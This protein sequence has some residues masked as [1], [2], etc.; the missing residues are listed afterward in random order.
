VAK[1][2]AK[3]K[4]TTRAK[5]KKK[6]SSRASSSAARVTTTKKT[7]GKKKVAASKKPTRKKKTVTR[8][9]VAAKKK[10][11]SKKKSPLKKKV[12]T[13]KKTSGKKTTTKK[14]PAA[15][16]KPAADKKPAA[17][18]AVRTTPKQTKK[19]TRKKTPRGK[20]TGARSVAEAA[21]AAQA[22][23]QGYVYINGRRVRMISTKGQV[24]TRRDRTTKQTPILEIETPQP[25]KP[26]KTKLSAKDLR[27]FRNLLLIKRAELVGDLSAIEAAALEARGGNLSN[28]PIHMADIGTDTYDQDFM[29]GLAET[30]RE[31]LREIDDA[32][33]RIADKT[34]GVCQMTSKPIP[35]TRLEA[36]PWAKY[37]IEA[38]RQ[39]EGQW[40]A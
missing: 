6:P 16:K 29:L 40:R 19:T 34:Y 36:K 21:S 10:P 13:K 15:S 20:I 23:A 18:V 31:R 33:R 7:P 1:K 17:A 30:E 14:K 27:Y 37:T 9:K 28:L 11:V 5:T 22:D 32:L 12:T 35:K 38:A 25:A 3:K 24:P 4:T 26:V 8:K 2:T 39:I